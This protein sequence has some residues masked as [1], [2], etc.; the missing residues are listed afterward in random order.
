MATRDIYES[1]FDED[2]PNEQIRACPEC[3]G[4]IRTNA[5][6]TVCDECGLVLDEQRIDHSP[7]WWTFESDPQG[8]ASVDEALVRED[9]EVIW[10]QLGIHDDEAV[11]RAE[12]AGHRVVQDRCKKPEHQRL[13]AST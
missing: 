12:A 7:E 2:V 3:N 1:G 4:R 10:L 13:V 8:Q 9:V 11:S 5:V 6:E